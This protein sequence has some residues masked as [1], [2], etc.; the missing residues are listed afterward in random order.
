VIGKGGE[1]VK[2][3]RDQVNNSIIVQPFDIIFIFLYFYS[4]VLEF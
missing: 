3:I 2:N 4:L 1:T